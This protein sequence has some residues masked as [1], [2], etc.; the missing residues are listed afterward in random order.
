MNATVV[1]SC[2]VSAA[3]LNFGNYDP[4]SALPTDGSTTVTVT[5]ALSSV[6]S[7]G[8]DQ[9]TG[10]GASVAV[11]KM[12]K[13]G[14]LLNYSL[15]Q[16]A[17]RLVVW[18]NTPGTDTL[19]GVGTGLAIPLLVYGRIPASQNVA[20]GAYADTITVSVNF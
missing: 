19:A 2:N 18:G 16:D 5:C 15:Y 4:V 9:G 14:A 1:S 8:L 10:T 12:S 6:Y 7:V 17:T 13:S 3:N 11:R 20:P